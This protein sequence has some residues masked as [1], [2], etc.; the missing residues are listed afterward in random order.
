MGIDDKNYAQVYLIHD[1]PHAMRLVP[2][3]DCIRNGDYFFTF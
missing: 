2:C 1:Y 3:F